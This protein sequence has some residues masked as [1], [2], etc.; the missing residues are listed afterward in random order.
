MKNIG[1]LLAIFLLGACSSKTE[2]GETISEG[3]DIMLLA[4]WEVEADTIAVQAQN[5]LMANVRK[6]MEQGGPEYAV[7]FCNLKAIPLTDSLSENFDV[8]IS[9]IT[10]KTRNPDNG[11]KTDTD[12][13]VFR[14]FKENPDLKYTIE[15]SEGNAVFYK[16]IDMALPACIQ[17]HGKPD[18]DISPGTLA[19]LNEK[20]PDDQA[21][22]YELNDF[23]G[24][25]KIVKPMAE[26]SKTE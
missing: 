16:R 26:V 3:N 10:D 4:A 20:Y 24:L 21:T 11:L 18:S 13:E 2:E 25:W 14:L 19:L 5:T 17:C 8:K 12:K 15:E 1:F 23:R 22:G 6:A 7:E 9:R